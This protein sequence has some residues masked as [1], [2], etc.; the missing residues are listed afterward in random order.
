MNYPLWDLPAGGLLIAAVAIL[1]VYVSHFAVGGGFFLVVT[2]HKARRDNDQALL[3]FVRAH[4]RFFILLTLVFGAITGVG[5]W[6]TIA[7]VH[8]AATSSLI[9]TFVWGWAIEWTFFLAE[10][11]AAMVYYYG[12]DRLT[13]RVHLAVGWIYFANAFLSL[14]VINGIL[15]YMLTPGAWL[16]TRDF[17]DGV[18]N[19]T[20]FSSLAARTVAAAG[21]AGFYALF[22]V[23]FSA[24]GGL[25]A[26]VARDAGGWWVLPAAVLLPLTLLWY[27]AAAAEAGVPVGEIL[28]TREAD[29]VAILQTVFTTSD[30]GYPIAQRAVQV[31]IVA[32]A[33]IVLLTLALL[34][35]PRACRPVLTTAILALGLASMGAAEWTREGLRKPWVIGNYMY[36][37]GARADAAPAPFG[38]DRFTVD[39]LNAAGV[40]P[41]TTWVR[42]WAAGPDAPEVDRLQAQGQEMFRLTCSQ[43]HTI[44]GYL[45]IRPLVAGAHPAALTA[46]LNRL[47]T[48]RGR[49]MPPAIGTA[50]ERQ[51]LA[52]YLAGL[53]GA[54]ADDLSGAFA[55]AA[56]AGQ[57]I[58]D[59]RCSVCHGAGGDFEIDPKGR[60]PEVFYEL[61][62]RLP[63]INE[64]MEPFDG[65]DEERR[66]LA[67]H[68]ATR[69]GRGAQP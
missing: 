65:T 37:H 43:C 32:P 42:T 3:A 58:F 5:I 25:R 17:W 35:R 34:A 61:I 47:D 56:S 31:A 55:P 24:D 20:Y 19:P 28:G 69:P 30:F 45:A 48:W 62:G 10:I 59:E 14:V 9:T 4:S 39:A 8:P 27:F 40:L 6:F 26:R 52:V 13:P 38:T 44:D 60:D 67:S 53:G 41:S 36:V 51:A 21:I 11:A 7:L 54:S 15:S 33:V 57:A 63:A 68:L 1:H 49:R 64:M 12:W 16:E 46:M 50:D 22:V 66:A 18:L 23:S 2:E 29:A